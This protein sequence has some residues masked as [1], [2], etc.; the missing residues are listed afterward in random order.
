[1][2]KPTTDQ[3]MISAARHL[4]A[5]KR[6]GRIANVWVDAGVFRVELKY[7]RKLVFGLAEVERWMSAVVAA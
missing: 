5:M 6:T 1:M 3:R 2:P 7:G 4:L